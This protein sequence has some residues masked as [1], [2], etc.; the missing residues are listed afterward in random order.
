MRRVPTLPDFKSLPRTSEQAQKWYGLGIMHYRAGEHEVA[1]AYLTAATE[2]TNDARYWIYRGIAELALGRNDQA[3]DSFQSGWLQVKSHRS[4]KR[5]L[6]E[7]L[8]LVQGSTRNRI[9]TIRKRLG[10]SW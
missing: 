10:V 3:D 2:I 7:S 6:G 9:E 5:L 1:L 8:E 4:D